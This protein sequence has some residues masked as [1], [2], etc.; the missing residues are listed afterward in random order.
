[1]GRHLGVVAADE[2]LVHGAG[3]AEVK[4]LVYNRLVAL[5]Y[6]AVKLFPRRAK[7]GAT[8]QVGHELELVACHALPR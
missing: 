1:M 6:E 3:V 8:H 2:V 7:A 4:Q 5:R